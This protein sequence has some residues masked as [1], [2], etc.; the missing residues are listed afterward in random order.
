M[1]ADEKRI[2]G[3]ADDS[4]SDSVRETDLPMIRAGLL[5][6]TCCYVGSKRH[7]IWVDP[8]PDALRYLRKYGR[9][10]PAHRRTLRETV[11]GRVRSTD[12]KM[13]RES[14]ETKY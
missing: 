9:L 3:L 10:T 11:K 13:A 8:H 2:A 4:M 5:S 6:L 12:I 1:K 7:S 14:I